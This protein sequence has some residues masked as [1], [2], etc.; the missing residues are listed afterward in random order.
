MRNLI[1][2]G[3]LHG[4]R[5]TLQQVQKRTAKKLF[6]AGETIYLQSSN[7]V[8]VG[9]S[10]SAAYEVNKETAGDKSF[11]GLV[12]GFEYYNCINKETGLYTS[13]YKKID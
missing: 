7:F 6:D 10:W 2:S 11:E 8:P 1:F 9:S 12:G 5:V 4:E 3:T 13:F